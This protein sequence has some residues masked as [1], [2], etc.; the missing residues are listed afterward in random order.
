MWPLLPR[1][2]WGRPG[3]LGCAPV[4]TAVLCPL[5]R[6]GDPGSGGGQGQG[7]LCPPG[8]PP[9]QAPWEGSG[10]RERAVGTAP[11]SWLQL[12]HSPLVQSAPGDSLRAGRR[13]AAGA[14]AKWGQGQGG[15]VRVGAWAWDLGGSQA[16]P[17]DLALP[18]HGD[19]TAE[20]APV[21]APHRRAG[22]DWTL[23]HSPPRAPAS[24]ARPSGPRPLGPGRAHKACPISSRAQQPS[25]LKRGCPGPGG[26]DHGQGS[27]SSLLP[28]LRTVC[29][30]QASGAQGP[31]QTAT[32]DGGR[33]S[34]VF[35]QP[36]ELRAPRTPVGTRIHGC[37]ACSRSARPATHSGTA[38]PPLGG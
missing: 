21:A 10:P 27:Q 26:G 23:A 28:P 1:G 30:A 3:D 31:H 35:S 16:E 5:A 6:E 20:H 33:R 24:A 38:A 25:E 37:R 36:R 8:P 11:R 2:A 14:R 17:G 12:G 7:H 9:C 19:S 15:G 29:V 13:A 4:G 18:G 32:L 22:R 34:L